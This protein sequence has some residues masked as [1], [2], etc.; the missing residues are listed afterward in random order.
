VLILDLKFALLVVEHTI[1]LDS[2]M[3][4]SDRF[5]P[6]LLPQLCD[7]LTGRQIMIARERRAADHGVASSCSEV[8]GTPRFGLHW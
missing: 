5:A 4:E 3:C 1:L 6:F 7:C 8:V 2:N